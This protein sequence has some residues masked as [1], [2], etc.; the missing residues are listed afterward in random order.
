VQ[1]K[2]GSGIPE[3]FLF[4]SI[5]YRQQFLFFNTLPAKSK[6]ISF[7]WNTLAKINPGGDPRKE[8]H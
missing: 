2:K 5:L 6:P 1:E 4:K 3:P 8:K 7:E